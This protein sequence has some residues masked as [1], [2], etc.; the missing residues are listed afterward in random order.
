[1]KQ[2]LSLLIVSLLF[3]SVAASAAWANPVV[4]RIYFTK[5]T[6]IAVPATYTFRFSIWDVATGG[7]KAANRVWWEEKELAMT[8]TALSTYLGDVTDPARRSGPLG[9]VDFSEQ[10]WV[11]VEKL[12]PDGVTYRTVGGRTRLT[13][14]PY[15]MWSETAGS[16]AD[17]AVGTAQLADGAVTF[18][19]IGT[20]CPDGYH[21]TYSG[22]GWTC[23]VGTPGADGRTIL[24]GTVNPTGSVGED[25]DFYINKTTTTLFGP[26]SGGVW[27]SGVSLIGPP[28]TT[29]AVCSSA[30]NLNHGTCSCAR[31]TISQI[32]SYSSCTAT[33]DT[34]S[35]NAT[36]NPTYSK[37]G[38]CCV[39][40]Y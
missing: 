28:V 7:T 1:M 12:A 40:A 3:L 14:V 11:M 5:A 29:S 24:N 27:P 36:G 26:K 18:P 20:V 9:D 35:C 23:G 32:T 22:T 19:K 8:D 39:C 30:M 34:G 21:P 37:Y 16:V 31:T 38:M 13:V 25:G 10:Y 2:K 15:A 33:A 17:G 4:P 6:E